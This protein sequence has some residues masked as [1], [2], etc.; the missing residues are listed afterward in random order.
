MPLKVLDAAGSGSYSNIAKG[1]NYAADHGARVINLSMGATSSSS[2]LQSAIDYAW[3]KGVVL[4][5]A[6]GNSG[7]DIPSYPAACTHVVAVSATNSA[8]T[9]TTWSNYGS[10]VDLS[11]P[12]ES[13]LTTWGGDYAYVS[14]TSFSSPVTA[15]TAALMLSIQPKLTNTQAGRPARQEYRR[16]RSGRLRRLLW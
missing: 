16:S 13:I 11:A 4:I 10:Y 3:N 1:I 15:A 14:G 9:I 12:G 5:A 8:D 7:N 6:A 2:T